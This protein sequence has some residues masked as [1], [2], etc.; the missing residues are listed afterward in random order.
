MKGSKIRARGLVY[1]ENSGGSKR[2]LAIGSK[3]GREV[4]DILIRQ[5]QSSWVIHKGAFESLSLFDLL[6]WDQLSLAARRL[7]DN[8]GRIIASEFAIVKGDAVDAFSILQDYF[9]ASVAE[10]DLG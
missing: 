3:P 1:E 8:R 5:A 10:C 9:C 2:G 6:S 4:G 7:D